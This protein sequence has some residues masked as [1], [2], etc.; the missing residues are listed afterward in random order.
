MTRSIDFHTL[1]VAD[2]VH[3]LNA[4]TAWLDKAQAHAEAIGFDS[5]NYLGLRL[6]PD[7]LPLARQVLLATEL[8]KLGAAYLLPTEAPKLA[9]EDVSLP[10][11][12]QRLKHAGGWLGGIPAAQINASTVEQISVPQ[13]GKAA[14][15]FDRASFHRWWSANFMFHV[16]TTYALLR[17]A[18]VP[19]GKA[20]FLALA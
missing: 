13:R 18:G 19:L 8:G 17:Q 9:H 12:R 14:L 15:I 20:D 2:P 7:M 1:L 10:D 16:T 5:S 4:M 6:A 3:Q 11:L